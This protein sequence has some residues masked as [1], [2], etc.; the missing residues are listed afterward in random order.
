VPSQ[1]LSVRNS[2]RDF[3][4]SFEP[5]LYTGEDAAKLVATFAEIERAAA[6]G[7]LMAARR[8]EE[9][10]VHE[11][12]GHKS[13]SRWLAS[14]TGEPVGEAISDLDAARSIR[15]SSVVEEAFKSGR[16]S[17]AQA[18][19]IASAAERR[20]DEASRL[21]RAA[22][23]LDFS[24]LKKRCRDVRF[25]AESAE[26]ECIRYE[27]IRRTRYLRIWTDPAGAGHLEARLAPDAM[28]VVKA[29]L[30]RAANSVFD[31]ARSEGRRES[32]EAYM[33]DALVALARGGSGI[34]TA[35]RRTPGSGLR[36][37]GTDRSKPLVRIRAD[38]S[39]IKRGHRIAGETCEIPGIDSPLPVR[40][41][42]Q[43]LGGSVLEL[44]I[45]EG[46]D[47]RAVV[48]DSRHISRALRIAL[49]ERDRV[50]CVPG[51][52]ASDHLEADHWET[53]F[54]KGGK[55]SLGNLALLC[56][57]HHDQ[58]TWGGWHLEGPPGQ[59]RFFGPDGTQSN[60]RKAGANRGTG[61]PVK[62]QSRLL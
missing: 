14:V 34:D 40:A 29:S 9:T 22:G 57:Y 33:A 50:C 59:W 10:R 7:K 41:V 21:V 26:Q 24:E 47:V 20:P 2:L 52:T 39:S 37:P 43:L 56:A 30:E 61:P 16:L 15:A 44:V 36:S 53:E 35:P 46:K 25:E 62:G 38:L 31:S 23:D 6:A 11:R 12:E 4:A 45:S 27:R 17:E 28:G 42:E 60:S 1:L 55:T 51:C 3:V 54:A 32:R 58:K 18:R 49:E 8:A 19:Q 13:A 48:T 5:S